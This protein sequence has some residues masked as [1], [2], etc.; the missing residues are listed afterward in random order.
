[1][2]IFD[3]SRRAHFIEEKDIERRVRLFI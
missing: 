2:N 1:M 3:V